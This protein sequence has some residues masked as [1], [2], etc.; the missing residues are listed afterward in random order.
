[1]L[2]FSLLESCSEEPGGSLSQD[3]GEISAL[4]IPEEG[5]A[6]VVY[7]ALEYSGSGGTRNSSASS[8]CA[9]AKVYPGYPREREREKAREVFL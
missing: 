4:A 3:R 8:S 2:P 7:G 1:M 6:P 5:A 9:E